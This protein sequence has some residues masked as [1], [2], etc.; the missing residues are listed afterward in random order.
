MARGPRPGTR[1]RSTRWRRA[2]SGWARTPSS[3]GCAT[4]SGGLA[5]AIA[6]ARRL[7]GIPAGR[8]VELVEYPPR[9]LVRLPQLGP[10]LGVMAAGLLGGLLDGAALAALG[11]DGEPAT[12]PAI[13]RGGPGGLAAATGAGFGGLEA[14]WLAPFGREPGR[15]RAVIHPDELPADWRRL[16]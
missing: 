2:A 7:A 5:D 15:P 11:G 13:E 1:R 9:P 14:R 6:E 16:D 8:E 3:A 4:G 12:P 10:R